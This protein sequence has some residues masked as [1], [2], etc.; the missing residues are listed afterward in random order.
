MFGNTEIIASCISKGTDKIIDNN[1]VFTRWKYLFQIIA[2][3][4]LWEISPV[5]YSDNEEDY[6]IGAIY[7]GIFNQRKGIFKVKEVKNGN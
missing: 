4:N 2:P 1:I 5:I 3:E 7:K 6:E